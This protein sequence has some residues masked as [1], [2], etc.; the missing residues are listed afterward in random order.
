M[1]Q[2]AFLVVLVLLNFFL[3]SKANIEIENIRQIHVTQFCNSNSTL[4]FPTQQFNCVI[5]LPTDYEFDCVRDG[6]I[7]IWTDKFWSRIITVQC[8][9]TR[10][11]QLDVVFE[12]GI[13]VLE[14]SEILSHQFLNGF[15]ITFSWNANKQKAAKYILTHSNSGLNMNFFFAY[16]ENQ[17]KNYSQISFYQPLQICG[18]SELYFN[19]RK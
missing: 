9:S 5:Y 17:G 4:L 15:A 1:L 11:L 19:L 13:P 6:N 3:P 14:N 12:D 10:A 8:N 16:Y 7:E 2:L 18:L